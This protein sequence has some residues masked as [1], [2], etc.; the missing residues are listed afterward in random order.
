MTTATSNTT[1]EQL[2]ANAAGQLAAN[3]AGNVNGEVTKPE[4][5]PPQQL[6]A[7][8]AASCS[9]T[10]KLSVG[11]VPV[12]KVM[13][14]NGR[15]WEQV[16]KALRFATAPAALAVAAFYR[17]ELKREVVFRSH[18]RHK[19]DCLCWDGKYWAE[20]PEELFRQDLSHLLG[21]ITSDQVDRLVDTIE[22]KATIPAREFNKRGVVVFDDCALELVGGKLKKHGFEKSH[23]STFRIPVPLKSTKHPEWD[24]VVARAF[25]NQDDQKTLQEILGYCLF[26]AYQ[27][28]V[29]FLWCG[30]GGTGKGTIRRVLVETLGRERVSGAS[31]D[32]LSDQ[33]GLAPLVGKYVNVDTESEYLKPADETTLKRI[34]G[35]DPVT[36]NEKNKPQYTIHL[37]VRIVLSCNDLPR[38]QDK[39]EALWQR[40]VILPFDVRVGE[41][42][43]E[44]DLLW[45]RLKPELGGILLWA[46][47][48]LV[49]V[50]QR[51]R[52]R[53]VA[54]TQSARAVD[55]KAKHRS[56]SDPFLAWFEEYAEVDKSYK[57]PKDDAYN[58]YETWAKRGGYQA[59]SASRFT[60]ALEKRGI[61]QRKLGTRDGRV[62]YY[63]G[64]RLYPLEPLLLSVVAGT[65]PGKQRVGE[66]TCEALNS[67]A[68]GE[69]DTAGTQPDTKPDTE[70]GPK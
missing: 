57:T 30:E 27:A 12:E 29:F 42:S 15:C 21:D 22:L 60:M 55:I 65:E 38:F 33:F 4:P 62:R 11:E 2:A 36:I 3:A 61:K 19:G 45:A 41:D 48:G 68:G 70:R 32:S 14:L 43:I 40:L 67:A 6:P 13:E 58:H 25:P 31:L 26:P 63:D 50:L 54:F 24:K 5:V 56:Y 53:A 8:P 23:Y 44:E 35:G 47:K 59:V 37:P 16:G 28:Q 51:K 39:S 66:N 9:E 7:A 17:D 69:P 49:R 52:T 34:T 46:L 10:V 18:G 1:P 64:L 20:Y